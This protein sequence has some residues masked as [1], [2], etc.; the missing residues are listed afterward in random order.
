MIFL[1]LCLVN[2]SNVLT[3]MLVPILASIWMERF[4]IATG[5]MGT[6]YL[7]LA[8]GFGA[9]LFLSQFFSAKFSYQKVVSFSAVSSG[10]LLTF[11]PWIGNFE[12]MAI[13][14]FLL[15]GFFGLFVPAA[16]TYFGFIFP[17]EKLGRAIGIFSSF[18]TAGMIAAPLIGANESLFLILGVSLMALGVAFQALAKF[19]EEKGKFPSLIFLKE[20]CAA[21]PNRSMFAFH[22]IAMGLNIG[23]YMIAPAYFIGSHE[24]LFPILSFS[25]FVAIFSSI[26]CGFLIDFMGLRLAL[27]LGLMLTGTFT[28]FLGLMRAEWAVFMFCL[29]VP[30]AVALSTMVYVA[31]SKIATPE[32]K[33]SLV[34]LFASSSFFLGAGVLP[35]L[36]SLLVDWNLCGIGFICL[37]L[38]SA[39]LG[40]Y[41]FYRD[42]LVVVE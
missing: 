2:F 34:S 22:S 26:L 6:L 32:R 9:G 38:T 1:L 20:A 30:M 18:Q 13:F 42:L 15:G 39:V 19:R 10:C 27:S 21:R 4:S 7:C 37:G 3:R 17:A 25:R 41:Y 35:Q 11:F 12:A 33:G 23:V 8:V 40:V 31:I 36:M 5:Q 24:V 16:I 29:Q 14:L 28:I